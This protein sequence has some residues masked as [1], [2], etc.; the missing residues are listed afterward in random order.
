MFSCQAE[1]RCR[2]YDWLLHSDLARLD[3][4]GKTHLACVEARHTNA[5]IQRNMV[6]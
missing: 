5:H 4:R 3:V 6:T 2:M 1:V